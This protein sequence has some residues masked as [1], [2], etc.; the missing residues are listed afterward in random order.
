[1]AILPWL[2]FRTRLVKNLTTSTF[3]FAHPFSTIMKKEPTYLLLADD[4]SDDCILF[5]EALEELKGTGLQT[6]LHMVHNGELLM[7]TL[8]ESEERLPDLLFLDLNMPRKN[9]FQCLAE[10]KQHEKLKNIPLIVI[11]T[12]FQVDVSNLLYKYG[13]LHYVQKPNDFV[14]LKKIIHHVLI[15]IAENNLDQ[16]SK[17]NFVLSPASL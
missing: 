4:D 13:A 14:L 5:K 17:E 12:S 2:S 8:Y 3:I 11:S 16:P 15:L 9:G 7:Q 10:I 6:Q 1:M